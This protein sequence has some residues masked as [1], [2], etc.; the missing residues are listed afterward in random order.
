MNR[1]RWSWTTNLAIWLSIV[2]I[3]TW[4][5][6]RHDLEREGAPFADALGLP[7]I[8]ALLG[9]SGSTLICFVYDL[10]FAP[11]VTR[12]GVGVLFGVVSVFL[13]VYLSSAITKIMQQL[14]IFVGWQSPSFI[15][16]M[17][18]YYGIFFLTTFIVWSQS[19]HL[20]RI[21]AD[22][23]TTRERLLVSIAQTKEAELKSL[24]SQLNPHFLFN[25][26]NSVVGMVEV[27]PRGA[28]EMVRELSALLRRA[29]DSTDR[30]T[31][32][33]G[34]ELEFLVQYLAIEQT[35][36]EAELHI[37]VDIKDELMALPIP[38][39]ILQPLVENAVKH[40]LRNRGALAISIRGRRTDTG[41]QLEV[42]NSG[43]WI[44]EDDQGEE[45]ENSPKG[46]KLVRDRL[47]S[48][49]PRTGRFNVFDNDGAVVA[50][51]EFD[52]R[53]LSIEMESTV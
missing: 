38:S 37:Q 8:A 13:A 51:V 49:Y 48:S 27:D 43:K 1:A 4:Q 5:R 17:A 22:Y 30:P 11:R 2:G 23:H 35:R 29:L 18:G 14:Y 10:L 31:T 50:R 40:G 7:F 44:A 15:A 42:I 3:Y 21:N 25:A 52:P 16:N 41:V 9:L 20:R 39:L 24:R 53:D 36:L 46:L 33:L 47:R 32:T 45:R 34:E 26:L 6:I 28:K 19:H 12:R